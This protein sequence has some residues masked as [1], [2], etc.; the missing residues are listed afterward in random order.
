MDRKQQ[1]GMWCIDLFSFSF[2]TTAEIE[3]SVGWLG[4]KI[5]M[6]TNVLEGICDQRR[7]HTLCPAKGQVKVVAK[8]EQ[9]HP[10]CLTHPSLRVP[11]AQRAAEEDK[12]HHAD[13][14]GWGQGALQREGGRMLGGWEDVGSH[15]LD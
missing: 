3:C 7:E 4:F 6:H 13:R 11:D 8:P 14:P 9:A 10:W 12:E 15:S 2:C 1:P 5:K